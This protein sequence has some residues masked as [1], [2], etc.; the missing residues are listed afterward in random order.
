MRTFFFWE[1]FLLK[2]KKEEK[3]KGRRSKGKENKSRNESLVI[4]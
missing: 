3:E 4:S 1:I 2:E